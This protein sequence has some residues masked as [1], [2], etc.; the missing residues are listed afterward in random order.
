MTAHPDYI[1]D[2]QANINIGNGATPSNKVTVS[3]PPKDPPIEK[4][5]NGED[6]VQL[7][8]EQLNQTLVYTIKTTVPTNTRTYENFTISDPLDEILIYESASVL[9]DGSED[10][11]GKIAV[12]YDADSHVV[13]AQLNTAADVAMYAGK[14]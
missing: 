1:V 13:T 12:N 8:K 11:A 6:E 5:V 2:N 14:K 10:S 4:K 3:P 9:V 7:D